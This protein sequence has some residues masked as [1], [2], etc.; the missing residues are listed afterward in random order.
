M[1]GV[2]WKI[3]WGSERTINCVR[4]QAITP[5]YFTG[6]GEGGVEWD[7]REAIYN[8]CLGSKLTS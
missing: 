6:G 7:D 5:E 2:N 4:S 1:G 3:Y 8:L